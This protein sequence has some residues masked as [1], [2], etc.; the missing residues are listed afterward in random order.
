M[1]YSGHLP[2]ANCKI[3]VPWQKPQPH[4]HLP[5]ASCSGVKTLRAGCLNF[6]LNIYF[7]EQCQED[8]K[9]A[10]ERLLFNENNPYREYVRPTACVKPRFALDLVL[11]TGPKC[12]I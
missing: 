1:C 10:V 9:L 2:P 6:S 7:C 3:A 5:L 8:R 4:P 11:I 12:I